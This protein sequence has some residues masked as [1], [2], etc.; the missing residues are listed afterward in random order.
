MRTLGCSWGR[1]IGTGKKSGAGS[2]GGSSRLIWTRLTRTRGSGLRSRG[3][4]AREVRGKSVGDV[5]SFILLYV[6]VLVVSRNT[7]G[8]CLFRRTP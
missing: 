6:V 7:C 4:L 2:E 8:F 3:V 5:G 1:W